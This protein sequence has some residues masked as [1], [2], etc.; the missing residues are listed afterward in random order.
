MYSGVKA[1]LKRHG[2]RRPLK[3]DFH[4]D[5]LAVSGKNLSALRDDTFDRAYERAVALNMKGWRGNVPDI[6]W[7]THVCC[8]AAQNA[9]SL[10]GDF[11][12]CGVHTGLLSLTVTHFLAFEKLDRTF[13]LFDTFD[14]IPLDTVSMSEKDH[15]A[16]LNDVLY[17]DCFDETSRNFSSFP[18]VKL[19]RGV[20]PE[21][22]ADAEI[23]RIAYL[24]IDLNNA[25]GEIATIERLW[26][27]L[28]RGA[29]VVIDDYAFTGYEAQ[30]RAWNAFAQKQ[31]SMILT[32]PTGQGILI[33]AS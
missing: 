12:E 13:W 4:A 5:G 1:W 15:A 33:K 18:N 29:I 14:G 23:D 19:V 17:F 21:S 16:M 6:R 3:F 22:L 27:K 9:L 32:V 28:S 26:Q 10:E 2:V 11:V 30:F 8:W 20:L 7:R 31:S 24:S 25:D